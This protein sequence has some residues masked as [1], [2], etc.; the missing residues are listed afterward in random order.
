MQIHHFGL[1]LLNLMIV[2]VQ[3]QAAH[4]QAPSLGPV[5]YDRQPH[6]LKGGRHLELN[7]SGPIGQQS[8]ELFW[9]LAWANKTSL[10]S[11]ADDL[12]TLTF[13]SPQIDVPGVE[14]ILTNRDPTDTRIDS[15][16]S[17]LVSSSLNNSQLTCLMANQYASNSSDTLNGVKVLRSGTQIS[18]KVFFVPLRPHL[19][20]TISPDKSGSLHRGHCLSHCEAYVGSG[21]VLTWV[22]YNTKKN[23]IWTVDLDG[24]S[25]SLQNLQTYSLTAVADYND[26]VKGPL[27]RSKLDIDLTFILDHSYLIC[28]SYNATR[29]GNFSDPD[30]ELRDAERIDFKDTDFLP[31][32]L[33]EEFL[34]VIGIIWLLI[35]ACLFCVSR[36]S[37]D[38]EIIEIE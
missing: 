8:G 4:P 15:R 9:Q 19:T 22:V 16:L 18:F 2:G 13:K 32:L 5:L 20:T 34:A 11:V 26:T 30:D 37:K 6:F 29:L 33:I 25:V 17:V 7:C 12:Q 36:K 24:R 27:L 10:W 23:Y 3:L 28:Y 14:L 31:A 38:L 35:C 21:G 1:F